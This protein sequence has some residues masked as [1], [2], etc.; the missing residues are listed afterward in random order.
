MPIKSYI[1]IAAPERK[2]RLVEELSSLPGC[3]LTTSDNED[4][5]ILV[6]DTPTEEAEHELEQRLSGLTNLQSL[7]LVCGFAE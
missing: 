7:S 6:T 3:S 2:Q 4:I 5:V 1:A